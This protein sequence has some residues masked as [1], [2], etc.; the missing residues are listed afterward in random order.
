MV[1]VLFTSRQAVKDDVLP[2]GLFIPKNTCL[3]FPHSVLYTDEHIWG[4][5]AL[6]FR[7]ERW[8]DGHLEKIPNFNFI[9]SP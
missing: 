5:D 7:P 9:Y 6:Q 1:L 3:I 8:Q 2:N 4:T